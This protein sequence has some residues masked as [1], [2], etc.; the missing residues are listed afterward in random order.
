MLQDRQQNIQ[1]LMEKLLRKIN[2]TLAKRGKNIV[3]LICLIF[4]GVAKLI[5]FIF[6]RHFS[7]NFCN[8]VSYPAVFIIYPEFSKTPQ[9]F[10]FLILSMGNRT[11]ITLGCG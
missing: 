3:Q 1:K 8:S 11:N 4:W 7:M 2:F 6:L 10:Q 5:F 9:L